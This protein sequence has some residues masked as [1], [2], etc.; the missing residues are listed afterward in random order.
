MFN[1]TSAALAEHTEWAVQA[2]HVSRPER[3]SAHFHSVCN[4]LGSWLASG[5]VT[6]QE[7]SAGQEVE[8]PFRP[9]TLIL[10]R[11]VLDLTE[12]QRQRMLDGL[13]PLLGPGLKGFDEL[14]DS[15]KEYRKG[16]MIHVEAKR[17]F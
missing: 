16:R 2:I 5:A 8:A 11:P 1:Q 12:G 9:R 10:I 15:W 4:A 7:Y 17:V 6:A 14:P 13:L 3:H